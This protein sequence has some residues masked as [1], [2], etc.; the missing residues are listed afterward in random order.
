M[1]CFV[2]FVSADA[3]RDYLLEK[4][5]VRSDCNS[6]DDNVHVV[7]GNKDGELVL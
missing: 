3:E 6:S 5:L 2:L 4:K 1:Y 7:H